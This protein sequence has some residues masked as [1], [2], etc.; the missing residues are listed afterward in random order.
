MAKPAGT[1]PKD[2]RAM[3][4]TDLRAQVGKL[5]QEMW[6]GKIKLR[7]GAA[8]QSHQI[9]QSRRQIARILTVLKQQASTKPAKEGS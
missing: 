5:R 7:E 2:L 1:T 6:H 8:Q 9:R 3:T 4:E